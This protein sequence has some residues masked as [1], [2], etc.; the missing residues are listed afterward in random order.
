MTVEPADAQGLWAG[1]PLVRVCCD[2]SCGSIPASAPTARSAR[3]RR[4]PVRGVECRGGGG[5]ALSTQGRPQPPFSLAGR[6][7]AGGEVRAFSSLFP[8]S[9]RP[10]LPV[11][12][13]RLLGIVISEFSRIFENYQKPNLRKES[14]PVFLSFSFFFLAN[15]LIKVLLW[16]DT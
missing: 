15:L 4:P 11:L 14:Y 9:I 8:E 13:G 12:G 2:W 16:K 3:E 6:F 10:L 7:A 5:T 1:F